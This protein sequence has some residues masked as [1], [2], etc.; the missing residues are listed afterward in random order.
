[1]NIHEVHDPAK[2]VSAVSIF[3][4]GEGTALSL[5]IL[6][7]QTLKEHITKVPA[8][9][10]C[11]EGKAVFENVQGLRWELSPGDRVDIEPLVKHW[12]AA[13]EDSYFLLVK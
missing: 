2:P 5:Q 1:M 11:V 10:V 4:G 3:K 12:V 13:E 7:G 8:L 6:K 9:L